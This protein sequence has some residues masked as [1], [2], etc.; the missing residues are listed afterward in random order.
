M[1][2]DWHGHCSRFCGGPM[3]I[4]LI[5]IS[6]IVGGLIG[7][8]GV[9]GILL[10]PSLAF[11]VGLSTH[12]AMAT[13]LFSFIFTGIFGTWLYQKHGSINWQITIPVC[14]GGIAG[15]YPGTMANAIA[16]GTTLDLLLGTII[17]FA[18]IYA[19]FPARGKGITYRRGDA[20]QQFALLFFIG[21]VVG[22]GSGL[23]GVGGPVLSVPFMVILGFS[24][25]L[26]ISTSQVIQIAAAVSGSIGNAGHGFICL[27]TGIYVALAEL[28]GVIAGVRIAHSIS[29]N[30]LKK[31][32]SAVCI[33]VGGFIIVRSLLSY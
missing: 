15:A 33:L 21:V 11:F 26:S 25:L 12:Q 7:T 14:M 2:K 20:R 6:I 13:A 29:Q 19:L 16:S 32:I 5:I 9:G 1:W 8:V 3:T 27:E 22:F 10:I 30:S 4:T 31:V 18:G 17:I 24:P 28:A 23:T